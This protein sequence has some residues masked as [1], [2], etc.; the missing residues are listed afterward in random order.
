[1]PRAVE[2][3]WCRTI[4]ATSNILTGKKIV[5]LRAHTRELRAFTTLSAHTM[6][7]IP[8]KNE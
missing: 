1:M 2:A 5:N 7:T 3:Q 4:R 8:R 6:G